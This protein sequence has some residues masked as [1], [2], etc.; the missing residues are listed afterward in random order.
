MSNNHQSLYEM[1]G[2][3]VTRYLLS[4]SLLFCFL[5]KKVFGPISQSQCTYPK[6]VAVSLQLSHFNLSLF[7]KFISYVSQVYLMA[8]TFALCLVGVK[9]EKMKN[10]RR[11]REINVIFHYLV[12]VKKGKKLAFTPFKKTIQHFASLPKLIREMPLF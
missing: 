2:A 6:K 3:L 11:K 5:K 1:G 4:F 10:E 12:R 7:P 9:R 8:L